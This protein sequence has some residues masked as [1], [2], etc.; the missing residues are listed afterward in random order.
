MNTQRTI[1]KLV[2]LLAATILV[3]ASGR[4]ADAQVPPNQKIMS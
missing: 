2:G 3:M 1:K 4:P